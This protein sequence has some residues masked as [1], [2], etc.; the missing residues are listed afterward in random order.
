MLLVVDKALGQSQST[1]RPKRSKAIRKSA[2]GTAFWPDAFCI[3]AEADLGP[4][5]FGRL[6][7]VSQMVDDCFTGPRN[8]LAANRTE[9][10][11]ILFAPPIFVFNCPKQVRIGLLQH[12]HSCRQSS[13]ENGQPDISQLGHRL[14]HQLDTGRQ[15][16]SPTSMIDGVYLL[17]A[18]LMASK[19]ISDA[20]SVTVCSAA[21]FL[22]A[23]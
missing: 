1:A 13:R 20:G 18:L 6:L 10:T 2:I 11:A 15:S 21:L 22:M 19:G 17:S 14:F 4:A 8:P 16:T 7:P 9:S 5:L 12:W 3:S 23:Q